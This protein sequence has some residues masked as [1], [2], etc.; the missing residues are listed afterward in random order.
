MLKNSRGASWLLKHCTFLLLSLLDPYSLLETRRKW[1][2]SSGILQSLDNHPADNVGHKNP[3]DAFSLV[4]LTYA[5]LT[6]AVRITKS[7]QVSTTCTHWKTLP[8]VG[9]FPPLWFWVSPKKTSFYRHP[10][11]RSPVWQGIAEQLPN[12]EKWLPEA[13]EHRTCSFPLRPLQLDRDFPT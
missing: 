10:A 2:V 4:A 8:Q 11:R 9:Y 12:H 7:S 1:S 13:K 5:T 6:R 3:A